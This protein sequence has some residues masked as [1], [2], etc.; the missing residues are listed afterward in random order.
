MGLHLRGRKETVGR[1]SSKM[2]VT[3]YNATRCRSKT[4]YLLTWPGLLAKVCDMHKTQSS[5]KYTRHYTEEDVESTK[6]YIMKTISVYNSNNTRITSESSAEVITGV[7]HNLGRTTD[8]TTAGHKKKQECRVLS[9]DLT[10]SIS[11]RNFTEP[12]KP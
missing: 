10:G 2:L 9:I 7:F 5:K 8:R 11:R 4:F 1:T 12:H 6:W 3:T